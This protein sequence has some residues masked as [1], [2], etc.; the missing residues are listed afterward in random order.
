MAKNSS[1]KNH[2]VLQQPVKHFPRK[3]V[4]VSFK[5]KSILLIGF[6]F[7]LRDPAWVLLSPSGRARL[8]HPIDARLIA[9]IKAV[10]CAW[11]TTVSADEKECFRAV[12]SRNIIHLRNL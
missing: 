12:G 3:G 1:G 6:S 5:F 10:G 2:P 11:I 7:Q 4:L 8:S 9:K